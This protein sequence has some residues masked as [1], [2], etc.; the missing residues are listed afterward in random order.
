MTAFLASGRRRDLVA[1]VYAMG[2]PREQAVKRA[3][4]SKYGDRMR[5]REFHGAVSALVDQGYLEKTADGVHDR[6]SLTEAGERA[7]LAHYE[8]LTEQIAPR[9]PSTG[10]ETE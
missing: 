3:I 5:P 9:D 4:E 6:V 1:L 8:W 7:L 2:E 10:S